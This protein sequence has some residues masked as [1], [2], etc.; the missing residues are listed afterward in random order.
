MHK[1]KLYYAVTLLFAFTC[2]CSKKKGAI[3]KYKS[4][5]INLGDLYFK[6]EF[7][8]NFVVYN[9]G[10]EALKLLDATADC[11]CTVPE[12]LKNKVIKPGDSVNINFK[13]TPS[14]D[15]FI[16]QNIYID[17]TSVN[18]SRVLFLVR[19]NVKLIKE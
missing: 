15:G 5:V 13:L 8:S 17:N 18:E 7:S 16:Q 12:N 11:T 2:S 4:N 3:I 19:A 1:L 6:K 14:L 9:I 10:D